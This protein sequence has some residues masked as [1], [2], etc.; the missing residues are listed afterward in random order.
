M[1]MMTIFEPLFLLLVLVTA[2]T[3]V[4]VV[5]FAVRGRTAR[6]VRILRRLAIGAAVYFAVVI[7]T[8]LLVPRRDYRVG[9]MQC[10]DDWCITVV[11]A[12]RTAEPRSGYDVTLRLSNRA[13]RVPM[14]ESGTV[15]YLIDSLGHRYDPR[16]D[17]AAVRFDT[18][19]QPGESRIATRRFDVPGDTRN[20]GFIYAHEGG[21][22][23]GWLIIGEGGWFR[24][25]PIVW[26]N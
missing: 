18:V 7:A 2:S 23:I 15:A 21:F 4:T 16:P 14:G 26:L 17:P 1:P 10:F 11:D 12:R 8:S 25:P 5:V 19:L 13:R 24:K 22:P 20:I 6:A 9:D 3:L